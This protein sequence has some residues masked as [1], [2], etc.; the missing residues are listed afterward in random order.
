MSRWSRHRAWALTLQPWIQTNNE[1]TRFHSSFLL[2]DFP[3]ICSRSLKNN[4]QSLV[5][6]DLTSK[7]RKRPK[8]IGSKNRKNDQERK[9]SEDQKWEAAVTF[10]NPANVQDFLGCL[11]ARSLETNLNWSKNFFEIQSS[12]LKAMVSPFLGQLEHPPNWGSTKNV[13][14]AANI[15]K[16]PILEVSRFGTND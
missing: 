8:L 6:T 14:A 3:E 5:M 11:I 2:S 12:M 16:W 4:E 10:E 1:L 13:Q 9:I 15:N 7:V